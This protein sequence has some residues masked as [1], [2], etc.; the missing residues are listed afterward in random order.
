[1]KNPFIRD[2]HEGHIVQVTD[3]ESRIYDV[4]RF[5]T[6]EQC[7]AALKVPCLQKT[8]A[9]AVKCRMAKLRKKPGQTAVRDDS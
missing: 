1:M 2:Y 3:A 9:R 7:E 4:K 8:V 5:T 6:L